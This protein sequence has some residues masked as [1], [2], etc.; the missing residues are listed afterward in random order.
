MH[1]SAGVHDWKQCETTPCNI[2]EIDLLNSPPVRDVDST[3][4][5]RRGEGD[6][7]LRYAGIVSHSFGIRHTHTHTCMYDSPW[8]IARRLSKRTDQLFAENNV[9]VWPCSF[10]DVASLHPPPP[11][12]FS[13]KLTRLTTPS[14]SIS[15]H[16]QFFFITQQHIL[17][18]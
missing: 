10:D 3:L 18:G 17:N 11:E 8:H 14:R 5:A 13:F 4:A 6:R 16:I 7:L 9:G 15:F 1:R 2:F 12:A